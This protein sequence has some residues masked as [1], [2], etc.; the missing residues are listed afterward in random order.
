MKKISRRLGGML[1]MVVVGIAVLTPCAHADTAAVTVGPMTG[2]GEGHVYGFRFTVNKLTHM[3]GLGSYNFV[4]TVDDFPNDPILVNGISAPVPVGLYTNGQLWVSTM[5]QPDDP[6]QGSYRYNSISPKTLQ[7]GI[8]YTVL[9]VYPYGGGNYFGY[10]SP[11]QYN[12][13]VTFVGL[14]TDN[15][16]TLP[17][18][19]P[20]NPNSWSDTYG[21]A[22]FLMSTN[23]IGANLSGMDFSGM[24]LS[25]LDFSGANLQ[26]LADAAREAG[27]SF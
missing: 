13:A 10:S 21:G 5:V 9:A 26:A 6:L 27:L 24:D 1:C 11:V 16:N 20:G 18:T 4:G 23:F 7:P 8:E 15:G 12:S 2:G 17:A 14:S 19:P 22:N 3:T 25:S